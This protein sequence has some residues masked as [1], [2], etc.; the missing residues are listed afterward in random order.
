MNIFSEPINN[1]I[2]TMQYK[3]S[4]IK[5]LITY[6]KVDYDLNNNPIDGSGQ[7]KL[8]GIPYENLTNNY[9]PDINNSNLLNVPPSSTRYYLDGFGNSVYIDMENTTL[10]TNGFS[11][12]IYRSASYK[13]FRNTTLVGSGLL[14]R[15]TSSLISQHTDDVIT[16]NMVQDKSGF[17]LTFTHNL[18]DLCTRLHIQNSNTLQNQ[19]NLLELTFNT[20]PDKLN[21]NVA[22]YNNDGYIRIEKV[23]SNHSAINDL[24]LASLFGG[25]LPKIIFKSKRGYPYNKDLT[26]GNNTST[27]TLTNVLKACFRLRIIPDN[28]S[29]YDS[30]LN[31]VINGGGKCVFTTNLYPSTNLAND[32]QF[33]YN[34]RTIS[35]YLTSLIPNTNTRIMSVTNLGYGKVNY[36]VEDFVGHYNTSSP[37]EEYEVPENVSN[38]G[39]LYK[40]FNHKINANNLNVNTPSAIVNINNGKFNFTVLI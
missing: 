7:D 37:L 35:P 26:N 13:L 38:T 20:L 8:Y 11:V 5:K 4:T 25:S 19:N 16:E 2:V 23:V 15:N 9:V 3:A 30:V 21:I 32:F 12:V 34:N 28:Y 22:S 39:P 29:I 40:N 24:D 1:L 36:I 17:V 10:Y 33:S 31:K 18:V 27:V 6:S 14:S